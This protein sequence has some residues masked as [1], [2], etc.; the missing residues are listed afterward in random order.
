MVTEINLSECHFTIIY[1]VDIPSDESYTG[2]YYCPSPVQFAQKIWRC[3]ESG[4]AED[5]EGWKHRKYVGI[6][7]FSQFCDFLDRVGLYV[8]KIKTMGSI[9][10][11]GFGFSVAPAVSFT[12]DDENAYQNAY[13]TPITPE[14]VKE[15]D[16]I[17]PGLDVDMV[18]A[19]NQPDWEI[20]EQAMWEWFEDGSQSARSMY[21]YLQVD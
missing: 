20:V 12:S 4:R 9:G 13:V 3:T 18:L 21:E 10:A 2:G 1:S 11:P 17:L 5:L 14:M 6:L 7:N 19:A 15:P 8:E 16:P